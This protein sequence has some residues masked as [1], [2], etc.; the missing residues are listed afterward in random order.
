MPEDEAR[1][2]GVEAHRLSRPGRAR[3]E[4]VGH[5][6]ERRH[7]RSAI[8]VLPQRE[9]KF[10]LR[11]PELRG[12]EDLPQIDD[13]GCRVRDLHAHGTLPGDGRHDANGARLHREREVGIEVRDPVHF[14]AGRRHHFELCHHRARGPATEFAL[15]VERCQ[16]LHEDLA[17]FVELAFHAGPI[18]RDRR[19]QEVHG[20][21]LVL[22]LLPRV[23]VDQP[24][25]GRALDAAR[26]AIVRLL[27]VHLFREGVDC[28]VANVGVGVGVG[29]VIGR[30]PEDSGSIRSLLLA[31][32][33]ARFVG[34]LVV[35]AP[36][37]QPLRFEPFDRGDLDDD[38]AIVARRGRLR[39][40]FGQLLALVSQNPCCASRDIAASDHAVAHGPERVP[41]ERR[42]TQGDE[43]NARDH[44][45]SEAPEQAGEG[46]S[47]ERPEP[48][49]RD[50]RRG[51]DPHADRYYE[52]E[53]P[54]QEG[55]TEGSLWRQPVAGP[56][57]AHADEERDEDG[58]PT[59]ER[60]EQALQRAP[61]RPDH[62]ARGEPLRSH[63]TEDGNRDQGEQE[64]QGHR[65]KGDGKDLTTLLFRQHSNVTLPP[66][67]SPDHS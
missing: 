61:D 44:R 35:L 7:I 66:A 16:A 30:S 8:E 46:P 36:V 25:V 31:L 2:D 3:D 15:D 43:E 60:R 57:A 39:S 37:R 34:V 38:L 19:A 41:A 6:L 12:L 11:A 27:V 56:E 21:D 26:I 13:L 51:R 22:D 24:V 9:R 58:G 4:H 45:R 63:S 17:E 49:G 5:L 28:Q 1:H 50:W 55:E 65:Q 14:D 23:R 18:A 10:T 52:Q 42:D 48:A 53:A 59:D 54:G 62:V 47:D 20:W 33:A 40:R 29:V 32:T 64:Q 67:G